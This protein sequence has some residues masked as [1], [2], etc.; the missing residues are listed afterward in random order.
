[1]A[2]K[3]ESTTE[4]QEQVLAAVGSGN[5]E[6]NVVDQSA[7]G[8]EQ[9]SASSENANSQSDE[10][11]ENSEVSE[12]IEENSEESGEENEEVK[13][14]SEEK[15]GKKKSGFQRRV[16]KLNKRLSVAEQEKEYW[17]ELALKNT[18]NPE[19]TQPAETTQ[20]AQEGKPSPDDFETH[21]DYVEALTDW[22]LE[23]REKANQEKEFKTK[24]Q[25]EF[26]AKVDAHNERVT[27]FAEKNADFHDVLEGVDDVKVSSAVQELILGSENGPELMYELAKN[28]EE[29]ARINKLSPLAAA[30][31][32]GKLEAR[33]AKASEVQKETKT[34]KAPKPL[35]PVSAK[36]SGAGKKSIFDPDIS[37][38]EYE[39]LRM[40]Q[41]RQRDAY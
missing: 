25:N 21:E 6:G 29:F 32:F 38:S 41:L 17:R 18:Q 8:T 14:D 11:T 20:K 35:T 28:R 31:E 4:T 1:M 30:R 3:I 24:I 5:A 34:T 22:K 15:A 36:T 13:A 33:L 7:Q 23:Q 26:Q 2:I 27:K 16:E 39:R 12:E 10:T 40:E 9:V 19:K 37:Q